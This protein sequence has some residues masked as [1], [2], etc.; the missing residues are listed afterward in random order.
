VHIFFEPVPSDAHDRGRLVVN[1][2]TGAVASRSA[3]RL[4]SIA[5][6][7]RTEGAIVASLATSNFTTETTLLPLSR[8]KLIPVVLGSPL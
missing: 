1:T 3:E 5:N 8:S 4:L 7:P 6:L 2:A